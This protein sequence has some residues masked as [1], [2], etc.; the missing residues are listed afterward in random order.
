MARVEIP[1]HPLTGRIYVRISFRCSIEEKLL[2]TRR[3]HICPHSY[4][5]AYLVLNAMMPAQ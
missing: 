2:H 1:L 3:V 5:Q 4:R